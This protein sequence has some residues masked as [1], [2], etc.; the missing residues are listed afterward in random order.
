[1]RIL[2]QLIGHQYP[3]NINEIIRESIKLRSPFQHFSTVII[4]QGDIIK[5]I[6]QSK[7][8]NLILNNFGVW[9]AG[10]IRQPTIAQT[11][12]NLQDITDT[13]RNLILYLNA[14]SESMFNVDSN[15]DLGTKMRVGSG[16]TPAARD[17]YDIE[18]AL[19]TAP[20]DDVFDSGVGS[21]AVGTISVAG[22]ITAGGA[23]T[24]NETGFYGAFGYGTTVTD[25]MLFHDILV[26]GEAFVLG[27]T[28]TVAYT[29]NL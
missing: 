7:P 19:G 9:L 3:K 14:P 15:E 27:N 12:V 10:F 21:Y 23:G 8:N 26:A 1:M 6:D 5:G 28:I 11:D 20:E 29:I 16:V 22:A 13:T 2:K 24:I 4:S 17:D 18:T 25:F